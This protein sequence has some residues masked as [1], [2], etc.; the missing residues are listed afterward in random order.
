MNTDVRNV[1]LKAGQ[2]AAV[3]ELDPKWLQNTVDA[4]YVRASIA[5]RGRG[6]TRLYNFADIVQLRLLSILVDSYGLEQG[7]AARL[8]AEVW[9]E[10]QFRRKQT[11]VLELLVKPNGKEIKLE[12]IR[13]PLAQIVKATEQRIA[14]V[15]ER[16]CEGKRGRPLGWSKQLQE[17][18]TDASDHLQEASDEQIAQA[19]SA[20]RGARRSRR[21][22]STLKQIPVNGKR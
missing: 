8:L 12:P 4:G 10:Q 15:L 5:G 20:Y 3:L 11:L 16:Y 19:T 13:L 22:S 21:Q 9:D 17:A 14:Q 2:V 1:E 6:S 7:R 18:I